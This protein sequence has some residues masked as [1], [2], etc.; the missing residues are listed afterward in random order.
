MCYHRRTARLDRLHFD[1]RRSNGHHDGCAAI[2]PLRRKRHPLRMVP[3][4]AV[5]TPRLSTAG[6]SLTI[7]L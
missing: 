2:Q 5:T 7:L 1:L 4:D 3:C 6:E